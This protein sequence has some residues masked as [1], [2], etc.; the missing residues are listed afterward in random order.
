MNKIK[1]N[2]K[3]KLINKSVNDL[4]KI[5]KRMNKREDRLVEQIRDLEFYVETLEEDFF[6]ESENDGILLFSGDTV[7]ED[8][9]IEDTSPILHSMETCLAELEP[10]KKDKKNKKKKKKGKKKK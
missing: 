7:E 2:R 10:P 9:V 8:I 3:R 6:E 1:K 5:L 4:L